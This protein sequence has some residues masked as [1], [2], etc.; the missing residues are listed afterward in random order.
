MVF[1]QKDFIVWFFCRWCLTLLMRTCQSPQSCHATI[2]RL[3][4]ERARC[5]VTV[6]LYRRRVFLLLWISRTWDLCRRKLLRPRRIF[7]ASSTLLPLQHPRCLQVHRCWSQG[8][9]HMLSLGYARLVL[10]TD[11]RGITVLLLFTQVIMWECIIMFHDVPAILSDV[12][13]L[14]TVQCI[15][16][17][18]LTGCD[19]FLCF[20]KIYFI[21]DFIHIH[22]CCEQE[23]SST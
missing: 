16:V 7:L 4:F 6:S 3:T 12:F 18:F 23:S 13:V 11:E 14:H 19:T 21:R 20:M 10:A 1:W 2:R 22:G 9:S 17:W 15:I 5:S 8:R